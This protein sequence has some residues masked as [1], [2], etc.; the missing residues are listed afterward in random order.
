MFIYF[1]KF[2]QIF[3]A[4]GVVVALTVMVYYADSSDRVVRASCPPMNATEGPWRQLG[5]QCTCPMSLPTFRRVFQCATELPPT[6]KRHMA[7]Y[8]APGGRYGTA[9]FNRLDLESLVTRR[10]GLFFNFTG[11]IHSAENRKKIRSRGMTLIWVR[12]GS[13][14]MWP[15]HTFDS[16]A[17]SMATMLVS[18][19]SLKLQ[20]PD[21]M[22]FIQPTDQPVD[23]LDIPIPVFG[24]N[25]QKS[26]VKADI[27]LIPWYSAEHT[28]VFN[29]DTRQVVKP[30][31]P[32]SLEK[33]LP[34]PYVP[35]RQPSSVWKPF[36]A[37]RLP[38]FLKD[39]AYQALWANLK[40]GDQ[41]QN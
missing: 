16:R 39:F 18:A 40:V 23:G 19:V 17:V 8:L 13:A 37:S 27:P 31:P 2:L 3:V 21:V 34:M 10:R 9:A 4:L 35:R 36:W 33:L 6:L 5:F 11:S 28:T 25:A 14:Y 24:Y 15:Q 1:E 41:L 29:Q 30:P 32:S 22:F 7:P 12:N 26:K 38:P 20:V